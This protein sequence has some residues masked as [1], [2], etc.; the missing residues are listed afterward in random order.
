MAF[1]VKN[2]G[3]LKKR[4][5][6]LVSVDIKEFDLLLLNKND[7]LNFSFNNSKKNSSISVENYTKEI[8][9]TNNGFWQIAIRSTVAIKCLKID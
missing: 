2:L 7:S 1:Y 3:Y 4:K 8:V 5:K 9:I 6:V